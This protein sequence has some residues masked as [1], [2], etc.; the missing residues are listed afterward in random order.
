MVKHVRVQHFCPCLSVHVL[1]LCTFII[2]MVLAST[3]P[4]PVL[5]PCIGSSKATPAVKKVQR[6]KGN[7]MH[8]CR[9][10]GLLRAK[11]CWLGARALRA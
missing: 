4:S 7:N 11:V 1:Q 6:F 8:L 3:T 9:L 10:S 2:F 5:R